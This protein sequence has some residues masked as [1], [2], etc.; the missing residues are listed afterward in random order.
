MYDKRLNFKARL[1]NALRVSEEGNT[2][3][4][5]ARRRR[6]HRPNTPRHGWLNYAGDE[7]KHG[8]RWKFKN[9]RRNK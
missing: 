7:M 8:S 4:P 1:I 3:S 6:T 2:L 5:C 9:K